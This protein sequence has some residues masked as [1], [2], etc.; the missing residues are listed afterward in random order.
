MMPSERKASLAMWGST[1]SGRVNET[2]IGPGSRKELARTAPPMGQVDIGDNE[3]AYLF[4]VLLRRIRK[5]RM[6][7]SE[8]VRIFCN[9]DAN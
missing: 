2:V 1:G 6:R 8:N 4:R 3:N 7:N 5:V 9:P